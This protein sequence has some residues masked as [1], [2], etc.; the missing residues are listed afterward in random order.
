VTSAVVQ[1]FHRGK[2]GV[3]VHMQNHASTSSVGRLAFKIASGLAKD[4]K[5]VVK[6]AWPYHFNHL[7]RL[8]KDAQ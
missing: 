7:Q 4:Y 2:E 6:I 5:N 1:L 8:T 3:H